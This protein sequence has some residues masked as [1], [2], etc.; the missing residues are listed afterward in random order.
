[1]LS[2]CVA[3]I[4]SSWVELGILLLEHWL[5]SAHHDDDSRPLS[6]EVA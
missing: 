1:M 2:C 5:L 4:P 6:K 3:T